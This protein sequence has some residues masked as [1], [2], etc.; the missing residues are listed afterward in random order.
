MSLISLP[1]HF[2]SLSSLLPSSL[3]PPVLGSSHGY[4]ART[5]LCEDLAVQR[6]YEVWM[7]MHQPTP[8]E[9]IDRLGLAV[10]REDGQEEREG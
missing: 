3:S 10:V 7:P 8:R 2:S 6:H 4:H 9:T 5:R 1:R